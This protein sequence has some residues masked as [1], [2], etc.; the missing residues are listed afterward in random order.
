MVYYTD[1]RNR[2]MVSGSVTNF[3]IFA[4]FLDIPP[5]GVYLKLI[6]NKKILKIHI[7]RYIKDIC[8]IYPAIFIRQYLVRRGHAL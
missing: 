2:N 7:D 3:G 6:Y 5:K 4:P 8:N 1:N